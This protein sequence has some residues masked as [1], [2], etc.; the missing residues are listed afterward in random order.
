MSFHYVMLP[1]I[2]FLFLGVAHAFGW[3]GDTG[4]GWQQ[5]TAGKNNMEIPKK[6]LPANCMIYN[7]VLLIEAYYKLRFT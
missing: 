1:K 7:I 5:N 2:H 3:A 6:T 4:G